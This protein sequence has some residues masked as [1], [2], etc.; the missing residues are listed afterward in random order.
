VYR[1]CENT[2]H[3]R[4]AAGLSAGELGSPR[5]DVLVNFF[6]KKKEGAPAFCLTFFSWVYFDS[7]AF[8]SF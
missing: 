7:L 6:K 2:D 1:G 3:E 8:S 5:R 4:Y